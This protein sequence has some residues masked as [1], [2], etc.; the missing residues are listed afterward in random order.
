VRSLPI[1]AGAVIAGRIRK[2]VNRSDI[3]YHDIR[4]TGMRKAHDRNKQIE[5]NQQHCHM[6]KRELH[7]Y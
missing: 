1:T 2:P 3:S 4:S 7:Y 6:A 5:N